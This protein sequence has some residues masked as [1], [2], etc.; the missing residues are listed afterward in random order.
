MHDNQPGGELGGV[1]AGESDGDRGAATESSRVR[2][3]VV[4][5]A[6]A[7]QRIDNFLI[8]ELPGVPKSRVYS[9]LRKG[10]VRVNGGRV[11][12]T[13]RLQEAD[14]LRIPPLRL[15]TPS[16]GAPVFIGDNLLEAVE[17]SIIYEDA[18]LLAIDKPAGLAVHGG[19]G[20]SFG[21]IEVL[22]RLRP[23]D[24][25]A[26]VHR[27]DRDTS[28]CLLVAKTRQA[29]LALHRALR[30]RE[31]RKQYVLVVHGRWPRRVKTVRLPLERYHTPSGE[32]RV[33]VSS[34]G[35]PSRT[36]F[37]VLEYGAHATLL[38]AHLH[39]G[40]THQIRVHAQA[41]GHPVVGDEKYA[42]SEQMDRASVAEVRRLC[43][44]AETLVFNH[45]G[46]KLRLHAEM[47]KDFQDAW[48]A[49]R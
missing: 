26:L 36:D 20:L 29:L 40:R 19:S 14:S 8:R 47:P 22:R 44:H 32:R 2:H 23:D 39:S 21:V 48:A 10:E 4:P 49:L 12:P 7:G 30:D 1:A 42:T 46:R 28:G 18:H 24:A 5:A 11:K 15:A 25:L 37:E 31:V 45:A 13:Y 34:S 33:R 43:L 41:T 17:G 3:R 9:M 35:K 6:S 27:L 38:R 16:A